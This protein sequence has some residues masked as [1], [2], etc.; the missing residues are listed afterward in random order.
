MLFLYTLLLSA[1]ALLLLPLLPL[2][3]LHPRIRAGL[4]QRLGFLPRAV[5]DQA[6]LDE[7]SLWVHAASLGEVN[8]V[9]PV[10][11]E[12]LPR[13]PRLRLVVTCTTVAGRNQAQRLFPQASACLLM[14]LDLPW[15]LQPWMERFKPRLAVIAETELWPNFLFQLKRF[16]SKVLVVN[17]RLTERSARRYGRLGRAFINVLER[18]DLFAMQA[19]ADA[20]RLISLGARAARVQVTGNT[21]FDLAGDLAAALD[22][23][24]ALRKQLGW[25]RNEEVLLLGS[26][27]PGEE[28]LLLDAYRSLRKSRPGLRWVLAPRHMERMDEV[29][30]LLKREKIAFSRRSQSPGPVDAP[31]L[32]LDSLGE[33]RSF[34][35][36]AIERGLAWIGGSFKDFGGQNPLEPAALGVPVIFG[37]SMRHFPDVAKALLDCEGA[38]QVEASNLVAQSWQLLDDT[39][40]RQR[41]VQAAQT[42]VREHAGASRSSADLGLRLLLLDRMSKD[43]AWRAQGFDRVRASVEVGSSLEEPDW[44][45]E[46]PHRPTQGGEF[47]LGLNRD[48]DGTVG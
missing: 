42:C 46:A 12:L 47:G 26:S 48:D 7:G 28:A 33:L 20:Q 4:T 5:R 17:G 23:V 43:D 35:A 13:V 34:Y 1:A 31:V 6:W 39:Q 24:S 10:L 38:F 11:R 15:L 37:P 32:L 18:V 30:A 44:R 25:S 8:A 16:G 9:A 41:T 22:G 45:H 21:K 29:A 19:D 40:L 14:P 2:L 36:L 27:R 3:L